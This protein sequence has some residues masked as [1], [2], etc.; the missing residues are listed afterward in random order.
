MMHRQ[1]SRTRIDGRAVVPH[2]DGPDGR[3]G[4]VMGEGVADGE[5]ERFE[6]GFGPRVAPVRWVHD[7]CVN[8][9]IA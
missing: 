2:A 3:R 8:G 4:Q 5:L 1:A 9:L 6:L 7:G